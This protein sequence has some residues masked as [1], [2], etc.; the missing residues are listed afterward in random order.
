MAKVTRCA[1]R[2]LRVRSEEDR[3][4]WVEC[5][6]CGKRGPRKHSIIMALVAFAVSLGDQHPRAKRKK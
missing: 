4:S 5:Q 2:E 3:C 6:K 1:H